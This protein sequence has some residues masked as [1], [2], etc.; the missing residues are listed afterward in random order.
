MIIILSSIININGPRVSL[1]SK[2]YF[3]FFVT[4]AR[5]KHVEVG[6]HKQWSMWFNSIQCNMTI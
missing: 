3:T 6:L 4:L 1:S 5:E 2:I